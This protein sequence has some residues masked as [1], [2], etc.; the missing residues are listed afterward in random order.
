MEMDN[1]QLMV[2]NEKKMKLST[3]QGGQAQQDQQPTIDGKFKECR[4]IKKTG[5]K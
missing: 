4:I 2:G 1:G 3:M 5:V